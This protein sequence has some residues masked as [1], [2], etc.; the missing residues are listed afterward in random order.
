[1]H[2]ARIINFIISD[3]LNE[4]DETIIKIKNVPGFNIKIRN[5]A[6]LEKL[7]VRSKNGAC[8]DISTRWNFTYLM[9]NITAES[10]KVFKC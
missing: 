3:R 7:K 10:K 8:L 2:R 1:V 4:V 9:L 6:C 5:G